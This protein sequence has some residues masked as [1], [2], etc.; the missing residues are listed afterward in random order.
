[1]FIRGVIP[2]RGV[3]VRGNFMTCTR[4]ARLLSEPI[5]NSILLICLLYGYLLLEDVCVGGREWVV[6][7]E[8]IYKCV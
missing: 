8:I 6:G 1:M 4:Y 7:C 3:L 2:Y 5:S